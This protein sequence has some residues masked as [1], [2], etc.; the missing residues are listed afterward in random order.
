MKSSGGVVWLWVLGLVALALT[1]AVALFAPTPNV[2]LADSAAVLATVTAGAVGIERGLEAFWTI[3]GMSGL[4][5]WWPLKPLGK[6]LDTFVDR[7]NKDLNPL[8]DTAGEAVGDARRVIDRSREGF[9]GAQ[10]YLDD[11]T[12]HATELK[13]LTPGDPQARNIAAEATSAVV[14]LK[15]TLRD[16]DGVADTAGKT[17]AGAS[18]FVQTFEDNPARRLMSLWA[19]VIVG[20][21]V[22]AVLGLDAFQAI[23]GKKPFGESGWLYAVFPSLGVAATG[24]LMGLGSNP[25]HEAIKTLKEIKERRKAE[26]HSS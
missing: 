24:L 26:A 6:R 10:Q 17:L 4:G 7:L 20:L 12:Q 9:K 3:V 18:E 8:I 23:L 2:G 11:L 16:I 14:G 21:I 15:K 13:R 22:A 1:I 19:G 25:A 5:S